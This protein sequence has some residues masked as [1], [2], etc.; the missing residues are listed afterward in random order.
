MLTTKREW[1]K[2]QRIYRES[3]LYKI[4]SSEDG[5]TKRRIIALH[6]PYF[7]VLFDGRLGGKHGI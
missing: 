3:M 1:E 6:N 2:R 7:Y 4:I 5:E